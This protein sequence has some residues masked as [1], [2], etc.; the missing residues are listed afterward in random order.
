ML[1]T[2][3]LILINLIFNPNDYTFYGYEFSL[4]YYFFVIIILLSYLKV[5]NYS[6]IWL[7]YFSTYKVFFGIANLFLMYQR[8]SGGDFDLYYDSPVNVLLGNQGQLAYG[9]I[10]VKINKIIFEIIPHSIIFLVLFASLI[11]FFAYF[12]IYKLVIQKITLNNL[13]RLILLYL[14]FISPTLLFQ[15]SYVGKEYFSLILFAFLLISLNNI[16]KKR[17]V[18]LNYILIIIIVYFIF[19]IRLYQGLIVFVSLLFWFFF[20]KCSFLTVNLLLFVSLVFIELFSQY[21]VS[22]IYPRFSGLTLRELMAIA[23]GGGS[24]ML[25]PFPFPLNFF[26]IFRPFPWEANNLFALITSLEL[27]FIIFV[28]IYYLIKKR[29]NLKKNFYKSN[30]YSFIYFYTIF[31]SYIYSLNPNMGDLSRRRV[32]FFP[33]IF[34]LFL[35]FKEEKIVDN[36]NYTKLEQF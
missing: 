11:S 18:M 3:P 32:Y 27:F 25:E 23:Y 10:V 34:I 9:N 14:F 22:I 19:Q 6:L 5:K 8:Y 7:V 29:K 1:I 28:F 36:S 24:L 31:A 20:K 26:Q 15:S 12:F 30:F 4:V 17:N 13:D 21:F 16:V 35:N 33:F 2:L